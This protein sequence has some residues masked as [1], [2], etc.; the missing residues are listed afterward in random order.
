MGFQF[1]QKIGNRGFA[2]L[3]LVLAFLLII[4]VTVIIGYKVFSS[5]NE[6]WQAQDSVSADA[7]ADVQTLK[8]RYVSLFDGIFM[9]VF[10]LLTIALFISVAYIG[11]RPEFFFITVII[12]IMFIGVSALM[13]NVYDDVGTSEQL[14]TT[15]SEFSFI[16][17]IMTK[18]PLVTLLLGAVILIG[19][20]VKIRGI[21]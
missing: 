3:G 4:A 2:D 8:D 21:V 14:A 20:Y 19:L 1:N 18:L 13:S 16:P 9:L 15:T 7:K 17:F 11:T 10:A 12:M 5:Y 6:K